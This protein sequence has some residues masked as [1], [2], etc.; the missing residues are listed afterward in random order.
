MMSFTVR[1]GD[2]VDGDAIAAAHVDSI[3]S[4]GA[5]AYS[6]EVVQDWGAPRSGDRYREAMARGVVFFVA[7]PDRPA[8]I[9][10]GILGFSSY[11][12]EGAMHRT[13]VYVRGAAARRGIGR[14]LFE[15]AQATAREAGASAITIEAALGAVPFWTAL[16]F[17]TVEPRDHILRSGALM[18]CLVMRKVLSATK[19]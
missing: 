7:V 14:A 9:D 19:Q 15:A 12:V 1:R 6:A 4:L 5:E 18:P 16:G 10:E 8:V 13:A 2:L 3:H 11:A 17:E